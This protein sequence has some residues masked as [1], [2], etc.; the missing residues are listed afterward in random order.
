MPG[1]MIEPTRA[2][3]RLGRKRNKPGRR[4]WKWV[5][6]GV[7]MLL[8]GWVGWAGYMTYAGL[9]QGLGTGEGEVA[10]PLVEPGSRVNVLVLGLDFQ[11]DAHGKPITDWR[12]SRGRADTIMLVSFDLER[13]EVGVLSLPRDSRVEIPGHGSEKLNAAHVYGGPGLAMRTVEE[14]TGVPVH[15]YVRTSFD[16]VARLVDLLGGVE[17]DVPRDMHYEDP[18]QN[19]YI[20][21]KAG[22]Q[23]LDGEAAV[24][25]LRFRQYPDGDIERIRVQQAFVMAAARKALSVVTLARLPFLVDDVLACVETNVPAG[26]VLALARLG[27]SLDPDAIRMGTAPGVPRDIGGVS[28]WILDQVGLARTVR[29]V[30]YGIEYP[31]L[32]EVLNGSGRPGLAAR[33]GDILR[34]QGF[35]VVRI[36]NASGEHRRTVIQVR[37]AGDLEADAVAAALSGMVS[38]PAVQR[39]PSE[40]NGEAGGQGRS[41][42]GGQGGEQGTPSRD[43]SGTAQLTVILGDDVAAPGSEP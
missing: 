25:L 19:L 43:G 30:L 42:A 18:Y 33:A 7:L 11:L 15:Y 29:Q 21:L 8:A 36:G 4:P 13:R 22:R 3:T 2:A 24:K 32:V 26:R 10:P 40:A 34:K 31:V 28:Y 12:R 16:G 17:F 41:Q 20:H 9:R 1:V 6:L 38:R 27:L 35:S 39:L 23:V 5:L 37:G 14:L